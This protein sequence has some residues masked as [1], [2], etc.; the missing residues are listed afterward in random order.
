MFLAKCKSVLLIAVIAGTLIAGLVVGGN[1]AN[2]G[3]KGTK[4]DKELLQGT[5]KIVSAEIGG[6]KPD[7]EEW[8]KMQSQPFVFKGDK[9]L[10]KYDA[11]FKLD[12]AKNPKHIDI[13]PL[14]GP[15]GEKGKTFRG[16]YRLDGDQLTICIALLPDGDRPASVTPA[17]GELVG[18]L[19][20]QR[21][22]ENK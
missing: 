22:K 19:V 7:D 3:G 2:G 18:V 20:F 17:A 21:V 4:S 11:D 6:K 8:A 5:W 14:D 12:P 10:A 15:E 9:L 16:L 13:V 1:L